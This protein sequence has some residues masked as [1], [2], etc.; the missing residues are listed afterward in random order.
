MVCKGHKE[1]SMTEETACT[2]GSWGWEMAVLGHAACFMTSSIQPV[3]LGGL[4]WRESKMGIISAIP[5]G[6]GRYGDDCSKI[7]INSESIIVW[8]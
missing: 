6:L 5:P 8:F 4:V 3:I 7:L 1:S 2:S